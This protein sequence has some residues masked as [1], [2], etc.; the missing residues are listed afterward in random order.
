MRPR[1]FFLTSEERRASSGEKGEA[2][3][4]CGDRLILQKKQLY[5]MCKSAASA[6]CRRHNLDVKCQCSRISDR[7]SAARRLYYL[8]AVVDN[9]RQE[10]LRK[11]MISVRKESCK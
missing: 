7:G 8:T 3:G 9:Y 4:K 6:L 10:Y 5:V 1:I 2:I 11:Y